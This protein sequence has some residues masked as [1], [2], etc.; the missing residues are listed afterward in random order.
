MYVGILERVEQSFKNCIL[1]DTGFSSAVVMVRLV[2]QL[3]LEEDALVKWNTQ[4]GNITTNIKVKVD[5]TLPALNATNFMTWNCHV[6]KST[7]GR[8]NMILGRDILTKLGLNLK[9]S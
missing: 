6:D 3:G 4:A 9:F 7:K 1:L 8:H 5:F 2:K